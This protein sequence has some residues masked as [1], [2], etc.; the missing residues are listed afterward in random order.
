[1]RTII[2]IIINVCN[3]WCVCKQS[4]I[5]YFLAFNWEPLRYSHTNFTKTF[6]RIPNFLSRK[7]THSFNSGLGGAWGSKE[8]LTNSHVPPIKELGSHL[9]QALDGFI[10][11]V[12][13]DG[14]IMYISET[15]STH[16]GLSQVELT[17]NSV[18]DYIHI[19]D[20]DEMTRVLS[21]QP[22][23]YPGQPIPPFD[24]CESSKSTNS[25][26]S[27]TPTTSGGGD[28]TVPTAL[29]AG[30]PNPLQASF[31]HS[32]HHHHHGH[33]QSHQ[34]PI[35]SQTI[36]IER[37]FFLRM[38]C[39][40]AK[41]NAGL[42]TQGYKVIHCAGY[43]KAR[44]YQ[45]DNGYGDGHSCVQNLGLVAVGHSLPHSQVT[46]IKLNQNMFMFRAEMDM[47]L[48]FLDDR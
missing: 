23:V 15:A 39:V 41:R 20:H 19:N 21:L 16:L 22:S 36:E 26:F 34:Q 11:V 33:P 12:A 46:E 3:V 2:M 10:F 29:I 13:P 42:T 5:I 24:Q 32:V 47:K 43:L 30:S 9:L 4:S 35:A 18:Y 38:K 31:H 8:L 6:F 40:L 45:M 28:A 14:K 37:T 27:S 7:H 1:M 44:I 17:G 48:I 25:S